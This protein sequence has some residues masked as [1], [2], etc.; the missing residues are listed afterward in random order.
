MATWGRGDGLGGQLLKEGGSESSTEN[1]LKFLNLY[2][3]WRVHA[4]SG[5]HCCWMPACF[6][7][8]SCSARGANCLPQTPLLGETGWQMMRIPG[9]GASSSQATL[10]QTLGWVNPRYLT[11]PTRYCFHT[12]G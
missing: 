2:L 5:P 11:C 6:P 1:L 3:V 7:I 4:G 10:Q 12:V 9:A 8:A